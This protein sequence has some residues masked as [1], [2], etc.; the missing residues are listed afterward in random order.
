MNKKM[1][2][3]RKSLLFLLIPSLI[4]IAYLGS[5]V[6]SYS[7]SKKDKSIVKVNNFTR[8]CELLNVEKH[9]D[10]IKVSVQNNSDKAIT[11]FALT[12]RIGPRMV[13]TFK[14][15]FAFSEIDI[16]IRPGE[17][18]DRVVSIPGSL[19]RLAEINLN[20]AAIM[21]E[22]NSSEGDPHIIRD[23]EDFRLGQKIQLM[24]IL[25]VIERLS[26]LSE[27]EIGI[28]WNQTAWHDLEVALNASNTESLSNLNRKP[29]S[30]DDSGNP[31]EQF[32][33]GVQSAR[34]SVF[35]KY[36]DLKDIQERQGTPAL[37]ESVIALKEVYA[38]MI[39]K[40]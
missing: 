29:L 7:A 13:F 27:S 4:G 31:S 2:G 30:N 12:S 39:S 37:R 25:P 20:L 38:R 36:Q 21:F 6:L 26:R 22:D 3:L 15:E 17:S 10:H 24:K 40:L 28:S 33:S 1:T 8:S 19:S 16:V 18:Y 14:E 23:M 5:T 11:A 34:E 9:K 35:Q 32:E